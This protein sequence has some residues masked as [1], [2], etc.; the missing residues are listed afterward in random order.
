MQLPGNRQS[1]YELVWSKPAGET[2]ADLRLA[3]KPLSGAGQPVILGLNFIV[4]LIVYFF[5]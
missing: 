5:V 2:V 3:S 4:D 1:L